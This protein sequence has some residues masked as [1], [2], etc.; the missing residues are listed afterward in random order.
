METVDTVVAW[1]LMTL[2]L[3]LLC[4][5]IIGYYYGRRD[6][7]NE[8]DAREDDEND[9]PCPCRSLD[10]PCVDAPERYRKGVHTV[11]IIL[12]G[13]AIQE[14]WHDGQWGLDVITEDRDILP[15]MI[16]ELEG[17]IDDGTVRPGVFV[18]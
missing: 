10:R 13:G 16:T 6:L 11:W 7:E 3:G 5:G 2:I 12:K 17:R 9:T 1:Q 4:V 14:V 18:K 8:L 15:H